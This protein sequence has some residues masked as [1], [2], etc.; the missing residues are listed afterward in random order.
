M[1]GQLKLILRKDIQFSYMQLSEQAPS[2]SGS[3]ADF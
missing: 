3:V 2:G 1:T